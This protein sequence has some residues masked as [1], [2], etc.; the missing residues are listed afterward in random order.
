MWDG[1]RKEE[2]SKDLSVVF[3]QLAL[4]GETAFEIIGSCLEN[5]EFYFQIFH[6]NF[7][8]RM[9]AQARQI[10]LLILDVYQL[11]GGLARLHNLATIF[12]FSVHPNDDTSGFDFYLIFVI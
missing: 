4:T 2:G 11:V 8:I 12:K 9:S 7:Q 3:F 10:S 6:F 5:S 1:E